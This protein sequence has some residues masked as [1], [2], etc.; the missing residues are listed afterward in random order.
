LKVLDRASTQQA[1]QGAG[2]CAIKLDKA[3]Q[4]V[5]GSIRQLEDVTSLYVSN[6]TKFGE[7]KK[8]EAALRDTLDCAWSDTLAIEYGV[9]ESNDE[10]QQLRTAERWFKKHKD[11]AEL[12][13]TLGRLSLRN[14][15]WGKAREYFLGSLA[16]RETPQAHA[17]LG[18]LLKYMGESE[19]YLTHV[20][21]G[22]DAVSANL[23]A[24]P[25]PDEQR[26]SIAQMAV[27]S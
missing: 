8:A 19:A 9:L 24:M 23:P 26:T 7:H 20:Q 1:G 4:R 16:V 27:K 6:M 21:Q 2:D 25:M 18:R 12:Q 17:E 15:L 11:S 13:L 5:T 10:S 22:F 14:Q 3:W